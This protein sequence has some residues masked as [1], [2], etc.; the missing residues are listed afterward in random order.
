MRL[1]HF[2]ALH[3]PILTDFRGKTIPPY[4]ILSYRWAHSEIL[5]EDIRNRS[6]KERENGY[7]SLTSAPNK[8]LRTTCSP[9]E[10]GC[11]PSPTIISSPAGERDMNVEKL[12]KVMGYKK[13]VRFFSNE[14]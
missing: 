14:I 4:A 7:R 1:L 2:D 12:L 6:Y 8:L 5:I 9:L 11:A 13:A 3:T 10:T